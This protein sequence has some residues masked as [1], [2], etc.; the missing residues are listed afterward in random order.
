MAARR[1]PEPQ[2]P[3]PRNIRVES[4]IVAER[5]QFPR[6]IQHVKAPARGDRNS[7]RLGHRHFISLPRPR[8][9][10]VM[11]IPSSKR[12]H[13]RRARSAR[14][15]LA[16]PRS[17]SAWTARLS[18]SKEGRRRPPTGRELRP[19]PRS[20]LDASATKSRGLAQ[21][22]RNPFLVAHEHDVAR[23]ERLSFHYAPFEW[24][25]LHAFESE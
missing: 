1:Q 25:V 12:S 10:W 7:Q 4:D 11:P 16:Q 23:F 24:Q 8:S 18:F 5:V 9:R 19:T 3:G 21:A 22:I 15:V 20:N 13:A 17:D 14:P 6:Q 2:S